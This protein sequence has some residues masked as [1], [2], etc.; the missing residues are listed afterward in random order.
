[1][2]GV[3]SQVVERIPYQTLPYGQG[4][5]SGGGNTDK[6][7]R[8]V[9]DRF[10]PVASFSGTYRANRWEL[11]VQRTPVESSECMCMCIHVY[12]FIICIVIIISIVQHKLF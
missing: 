9:T 12:L 10:G 3:S 7:L 6:L 8:Y 2:S 11:V 4:D 1:M 5:D